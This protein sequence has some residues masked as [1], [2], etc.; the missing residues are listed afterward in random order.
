MNYNVIYINYKGKK[1]KEMYENNEYSFP[2]F[3]DT[4]IESLLKNG[5]SNK[6]I[7]S[8]D[9]SKINLS[10]TMVIQKILPVM[11][12]RGLTSIDQSENFFI[13]S[14][15]KFT[16]FSFFYN[17]N[18]IGFAKGKELK[19][20][21]P[22]P[23]YIDHCEMNLTA[24]LTK[25]NVFN[26]LKIEEKLG[27]VLIDVQISKR[28]KGL[29]AKMMKSAVS[30]FFSRKPVSL[31]VSIFEPK[32][33]LQRITDYFSFAPEFLLKSSKEDNC[34]ERLKLIITYSISGLYTASKQLKPFN[35]LLGET[36]E[37]VF[38]DNSRV[39][40]EQISHYPTVARFYLKDVD[41]NYTFHGFYDIA[42]VNKHL[43]KKITVIQGGPN[44]V[45]IK[46]YNSKIVYNLPKINML[47]CDSEV[48]RST[49][50]KSVMVF[51]D[52]QNGLKAVLKFGKNHS[53]VNTFEGYIVSFSF[54]KNYVFNIKEEVVK[55][56]K[57][58]KEKNQVFLSRIN[59][60]WLDHIKF[61][62]KVYWNIDDYSPI[63]IKPVEDVIPSDSRFREDLIWLFRC[64][65]AKNEED[66][67]RFED[68]SQNWKYLLEAIQR[69][70]RELRKSKK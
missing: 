6:F 58:F 28:F 46:K 24:N 8:L 40:C 35:P 57:F 39:Y 22:S 3:E 54:P 51:V 44:I 33:M 42:T 5:N 13:F 21:F 52:T 41:N 37:G 64:F 66:K 55:A 70:D 60:N 18:K 4:K 30:N 14:E 23:S 62:E 63:T 19:L 16:P 11:L 67:K 32:S 45:E 25:A 10:K 53:N 49:Y 56:K 36:F 20:N 38:A 68:F 7:N 29:M 65:S 50:W 9:D 12:T 2:D 15:Y 48:N 61:D 31:P 26:G 43:G 47:N 69:S 34:L 17:Q 1:G 27:L 59:G